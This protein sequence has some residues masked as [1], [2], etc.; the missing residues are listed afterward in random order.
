MM[1]LM[2]LNEWESGPEDPCANP[3]RFPQHHTVAHRK[4]LILHKQL[5]IGSLAMLL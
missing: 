3:L 4:L 5:G 1:I 2:N